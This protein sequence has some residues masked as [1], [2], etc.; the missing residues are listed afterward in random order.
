MANKIISFTDLIAWQEGHKLVITIYKIANNFPK[1][2]AFG[3]FSQI[4]RAAVSVTSNI[5]EGFARQ[6]KKEKRQFY[7]TAKGSLVE[8]EN[9]LLIARDI[10]YLAK[11]DFKKIAKQ[12]IVVDKLISGLIKAVERRSNLR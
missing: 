8:V 11:E 9:Q 7:Y 1:R 6:T 2:E 12:A 10:S 5:A 4:T 3:L